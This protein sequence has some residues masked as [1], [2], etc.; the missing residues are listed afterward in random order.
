MLPILRTE[1]LDLVATTG[2]HLAAELEAPSSLAAL[3]GAVVP[4]SWPPGEYDRAAMEFFR[5][6]LEI[7]GPGAVGWYGWYVL[8]RGAPGAADA[9]G[10]LHAAAPTLV[11]GAGYFGPPD[12]AGEVELGYSVVP[13]YAGRGIAT[14]AVRALTDRALAFPGVRLVRAH[15]DVAN[16]ASR[17]VL[18]RSE[19]REVGRHPESG[20]LRYERRRAGAA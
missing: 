11:A 8:L 16:G 7:E 18:A 5:A 17:A 20:Q 12:A 10:T 19:F 15:V 1:R 4:A 6:R 9:D 13:E 3:L 14:E 2:D